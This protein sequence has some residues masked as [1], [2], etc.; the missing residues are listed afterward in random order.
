MRLGKLDNDELERLVLSKFRRK[1]PESMTAPSIGCDCAMLDL[2]GDLAVLSS[3]PIT[4]AGI[5]HLGQLTVHVNCNDAASE[6]AEPVGL[7]VTL[8][9]P[10]HATAQE[11]ER[12]AEDLSRAADSANVDII[13]GH[14]EVTDAVTRFVTNTAVVA[15]IDRTRCMTRLATGNDIVMTKWAALEG[16]S[17]AAAEFADQMPALDAKTL[18]AAEKL[19]ALLSIVPESRIAISHGATAMHDVTEGGVLGAVWELSYVGG[20]GIA[21]DVDAIPILPETREICAALSLDPLR[22]IGSGSLLIACADGPALVKALA[23]AGIHAAV[24]GRAQGAGVTDIQGKKIE[25]PQADEIYR[26]YKQ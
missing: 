14:T 2:G 13:G 6:G 8:L 15:R 22:L 18:E 21:V 20:C 9:A 23:N 24:I 3:D 12:I 25:P 10:P 26:L 11:I 4:S 16:T 5:A 7:L 19:A 17:I 1:R